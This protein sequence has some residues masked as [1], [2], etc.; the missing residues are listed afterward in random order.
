LLTEAETLNRLTEQIVHAAIEVHKTLGPGLLE[1]TYRICTAHELGLSGLH[2]SQEV[3]L[4]VIYKNVR[5]DAGYR[6]DMVVNDLVVVE[7]KSVADLLPIH[8]A[9]VIS[10]LRL[11]GF[12]VGLLINFNVKI[13]KNG[14]RRIVNNF[15]DAGRA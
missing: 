1:S 10:Y 2:V 12:K 8:E 11:A 9:Q 15:P 6:L 5:L 13:L 3:P 14:I 4:P 7:F